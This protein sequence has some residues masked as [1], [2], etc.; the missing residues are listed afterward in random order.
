MAIKVFLAD[1]HAVVRDG[2]RLLLEAKGDITVIGEAA[3]GFE[4]VNK[5]EQL[6]P[7]VV[8]MDIAM[9]EM[10]G[11]EATQQICNACPSTQVVILSMHATTE[12]IYRAL[13]AGAKGY[14]LKE[15]AGADVV[16]AV[17]TV[18][19]GRRYLSRQITE[20]VIDDYII[21]HKDSRDRSPLENL[22]SREKEILQ[23][24]VEG[25][26]S[27]QIAEILKISPKTVD[28]YRSRLMRKL[29]VHD[30]PA[31]VKFAIQHGITPLK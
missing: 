29:D 8:L 18:H 9:P 10:S 17:R 28:T 1:D 12:H 27:A 22:S 7:D 13:K 3:D 20:A 2:L 6:K 25:K 14:L 30:I 31:L 11:I 24:V 16:K 23:M 21:R 26:S 4:T 15:S 19:L 5:V